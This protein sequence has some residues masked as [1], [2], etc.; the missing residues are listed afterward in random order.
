MGKTVKVIKRSRS[1][2]EL[3][4]AIVDAFHQRDREVEDQKR[5]KLD[6]MRSTVG[7]HDPKNKRSVLQGI[8]KLLICPKKYKAGNYGIGSTVLLSVFL[9]LIFLAVEYALYVAIVYAFRPIWTHIQYNAPVSAIFLVIRGIGSLIISLACFFIARLFR[10]MRMELDEMN[11][12]DKF[13][14]FFSAIMAV[15]A[16]FFNL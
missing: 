6:E 9:T 4:Q 13:L 12:R 5:K 8:F 11:D 16:I 14:A 1:Q 2:V 10:V 3:T 15:V 7:I